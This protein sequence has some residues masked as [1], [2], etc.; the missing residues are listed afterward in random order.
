MT[1]S[2]RLSHACIYV[3]TSTRPLFTG[4][5]NSGN[6]CIQIIMCMSVCA[7][8]C[9]CTC[10]CVHVCVYLGG[11]RREGVCVCVRERESHCRPNGIML[12]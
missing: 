4:V 6:V 1:P 9:T 8:A 3:I 12:S 2:P 11:W 10:A 5:Q 7:C